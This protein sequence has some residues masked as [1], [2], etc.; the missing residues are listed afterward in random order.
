MVMA[1][2][3]VRST[4]KRSKKTQTAADRITNARLLKLAS[5]NRPPQKWFDQTDVPFTPAKD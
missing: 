2:T 3:R 5:K 4:R 1:A